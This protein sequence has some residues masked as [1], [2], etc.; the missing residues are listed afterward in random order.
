MCIIGSMDIIEVSTIWDKVK[1]DLE[2]NLPEHVYQ[3]WVT[4]LGAAAFEN[5][6][7]VLYSPHSMAVDI[8]K[9]SWIGRIRESVKKILGA[10]A[11]CSINYDEEY[12]KTYIKSQKNELKRQKA[13]QTQEEQKIEDSKQILA[14]MQSSA[15][16]NLNLKFENFVVGE[17]SKFAYNVAYSVANNPSKQ[18]NPLFIYGASG[19]GKTHL[20]QA[21]GHY[22]I[23]N[24]P[25]LTVKYIRMDEYYNE[26]MRCYK[27]NESPNAKKKQY[28]DNAAMRKFH[29]KFSNVDI[30]LMDDIQFL[31]SKI[32]TMENFFSIFEALYTNNKQ[33]VIA[34]DREPKDIPTLDKRLRTRFEMGIVVDI[35]PP[36]F[37]TRYEIV[38]AYAKDL[39]IEAEDDAFKFIAENFDNNVRELKG[40]VNK[41]SAFA[42]FSDIGLITKDLAQQVLKNSI[43]KNEL[44][45]DVIAKIVADYFGLDV[46]DLKSS[47]RQQKISQARQITAYLSREILEQ[48]YEAI[49]EY[50][51]KKHTT[52]L[53]SCDTIS[54]KIKTDS[55][56]KTMIQDISSKIKI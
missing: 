8:L 55:N 22:I 49:A 6:T 5:D 28:C 47:A 32:K 56:F 3:N 44:T 24:R 12:A 15:N 20:L 40:A 36:D 43:K 9:K 2:E 29:Q 11:T 37:Q 45:I 21:I 42:S 14:K 18:F 17:N 34:S 52:I 19:L 27:M 25:D 10:N 54:E 33:I 46:K 4:P 51:E 31:E 35:L 1:K 7:L 50:L 26:M 16:L 41:I 38:K 48:S 13:G 23:F 53:Y 30:L 39:D